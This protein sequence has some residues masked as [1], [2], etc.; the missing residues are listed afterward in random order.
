MSANDFLAKLP[1]A[2]DSGAAAGTDCT[3]QFNI[4][5]PAYVVIRN[6]TCEVRDGTAASSDV[7]LTMADDDLVQ[8][9]KGELSGMS[10]FMS[11]KL[12]L[13]GDMMLAQ[14]IATLFDASKL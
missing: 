3:I 7:A 1:A 13:D 5:K 12:Q 10:A 11:G 2:L 9:L 6:G 4:A 8:M 14:R